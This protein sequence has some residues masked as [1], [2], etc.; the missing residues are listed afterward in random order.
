MYFF[1]SSVRATSIL[2]AKLMYPCLICLVPRDLL[3]DLSEILYPRWTREGTLQLV[4]RANEAS[5]KKE[6]K[7]ILGSQSIRN[8]SVSQV[9]IFECYLTVYRIH[10]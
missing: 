9:S 6:A 10:F 2:G 7:D 4:K 3:W 5:S 8:V 1:A